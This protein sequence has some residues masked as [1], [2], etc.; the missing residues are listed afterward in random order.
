MASLLVRVTDS[1]ESVVS[2][3]EGQQAFLVTYKTVFLAGELNGQKDASSSIRIFRGDTRTFNLTFALEDGTEENIT[4]QELWITIKRE[5]TDSDDLS[6]IQEKVVFQ[7]GSQSEAGEGAITLGS[8]K[9]SALDP[10]PYLYDLQKVAPGVPPVV[11]T[12]VCGQLIVLPDIT[13][14]DGS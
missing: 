14:R 8:D 11:T 4:G 10:G 1:P 9:T 2:V 5:F 3:G 6:V 7:A 12:L 13:Q